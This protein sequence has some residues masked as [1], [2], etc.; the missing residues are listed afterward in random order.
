PRIV[1]SIGLLIALPALGLFVVDKIPEAA[2]V[3]TLALV[4]GIGPSPSIVYRPF[5]GLVIDS[6]QLIMLGVA[7]ISALALWYLVTRTRLGLEMRGVVD[8]RQVAELRGISAAGPSRTAW[9][10]GS[11]LAGLIGV[12]GGPLFGLSTINAI[13]F[14]VVSSAVVVLAR[15]R[16]LPV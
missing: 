16:N 13:Q 9:T 4:P 1:G 7:L 12:A 15:F 10:L 11:V 2:S 5:D 14:V 6:N 3:Q 8:R